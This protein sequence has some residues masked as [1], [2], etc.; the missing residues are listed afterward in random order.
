MNGHRQLCVAG[1]Q[2]SSGLWLLLYMLAGAAATG[3]AAGAVGAE[4]PAA[5]LHQVPP[6]AL[7]IKIDGVIDEQAW[8][9]ALR[10]TLDVETEP[11][12]NLPAPVATECLLTYGKN[13]LYVA[14]RAHDPEPSKIRARLA[15]RDAASSDDFVGVVLDTFNDERRA[16]EFF[17]NPRGVQMDR[18]YDDINA[19]EDGSW[20]AI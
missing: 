1:K 12:E 3:A 4:A 11:G 14:F 19:N 17:V 13:A 8:R 10:I 16:F 2:G 15:D 6:T 18:T 7:P 9:D 5:G 20:D